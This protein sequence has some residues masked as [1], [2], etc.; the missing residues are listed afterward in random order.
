M[1]KCPECK[2]ELPIASKFKKEFVCQYCDSELKNDFPLSTIL[3]CLIFA[4]TLVYFTGGLSGARSGGLIAFIVVGSLFMFFGVG[5][6]VKTVGSKAADIKKANQEKMA[7]QDA[8]VSKNIA[9]FK[10][11]N[12][13]K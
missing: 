12:T 9:A 3:G 1:I 6:K 13:K 4:V 2:S 10:D 5:L 11:K 8:Q 7:K